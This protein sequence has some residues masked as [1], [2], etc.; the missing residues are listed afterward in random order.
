MHEIAATKKA[1]MWAAIAGIAHVAILAFGTQF[2]P[3][4][5]TV[6]IAVAYGFILPP[7]AVLHARNAAHRQ[8]GAILGSLAANVTVTV[9]LGASLNADLRPAALFAIG[10][11]WWTIG[12]LAFETGTLPRTFGLVTAG[13]GAIAFLFAFT[14]SV[15][16][17]G[18]AY[19]G[20]MPELPL[21]DVARAALG[22]WLLT[23]AVVLAR[24]QTD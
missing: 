4:L 16:A 19:L 11:W 22:A 6:L 20:A 8:S 15:Q 21:W 24:T 3:Y 5:F 1:V 14:V 23:L 18:P 17:V 9:G 2:Y 7:A 13:A 12:K 10:M